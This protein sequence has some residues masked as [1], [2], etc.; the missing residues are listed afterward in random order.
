M[1]HKIELEKN[2]WFGFR[3]LDSG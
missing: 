1:S 2:R 3:I